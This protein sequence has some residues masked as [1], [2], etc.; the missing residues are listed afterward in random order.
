MLVKYVNTY[1]KID[2]NNK[3]S[4]NLWAMSAKLFRFPEVFLLN[5]GD[6][7]A[8][9]V[10]RKSVIFDNVVQSGS[11]RIVVGVHEDVVDATI[12]K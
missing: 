11:E 1:K 10:N 7:V 4:K 6:I 12:L 2:N 3:N 8:K 9:L 5:P